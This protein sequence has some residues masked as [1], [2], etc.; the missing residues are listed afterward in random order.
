MQQLITGGMLKEGVWQSSSCLEVK[1]GRIIDISECVT[2]G[3]GP[4]DYILP[5][6][7]NCHSHVFQRAMAGLT[8]YRCGGEDVAEDNFWTWRTLMYQQAGTMTPDRLEEIAADCYREMVQR[9]YTSVGEFHY[10]HNSHIGQQLAMAEAIIRAA[11]TAGIGLTLLPVFFETAGFGDSEP[12][13]TQRPFVMDVSRYISFLK[14]LAARIERPNRLGVAFHSLRAVKPGSFA[15]ILSALNAID[16][17]APIHIHIAEQLQEVE[18][19]VQHTG[20]RPIEWLMEHQPVDSRW[21]LVHATHL[22][23][24]EIKSIADSGAIVGLCPTT[25][26]NLGDG[27]FPL[28]AFLAAG[29][30]FCIGSDSNVC[31]D[32]CEELRLLEYTQRLID[33]RRVILTPNDGNHVGASLWAHAARY[34]GL[35]LGRSSGTVSKG[36]VADLVFLD[37]KHSVLSNANGAQVAD[38][39]VFVSEGGQIKKTVVAGH[40]VWEKRGISV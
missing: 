8:E 11:K 29:G 25:E 6:M 20:M 4:A 23:D 15:P 14:A 16:D 31:L 7:A 40:P 9:G 30:N 18:D 26:A 12:G 28:Q 22:T 24:A 2:A 35:A 37:A 19:C 38:A 1:D 27:I 21:C 33:K 32:P 13:E 17:Q 10:L 3:G 5:G 36:E 39:Y 34:G